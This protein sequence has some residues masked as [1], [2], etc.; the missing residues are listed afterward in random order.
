MNEAIKRKAHRTA[1]G[2]HQGELVGQREVTEY[3]DHVK[4]TGNLGGDNRVRKENFTM[5]ACF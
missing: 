3:S 5:F 1:E 2:P 4:A